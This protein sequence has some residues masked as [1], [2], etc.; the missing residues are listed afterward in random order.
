[1]F[2]SPP[3]PPPPPTTPEEGV[4]A[5]AVLIIL[6][7]ILSQY[8][9]TEDF[10]EKMSQ[11][12]GTL[13][14]VFAPSTSDADVQ[15]PNSLVHD[16][17]SSGILSPPS[18]VPDSSCQKGLLPSFSLKVPDDVN[19]VLHRSNEPYR[20]P[21]RYKV[22][23]KQSVS[24]I[25]NCEDISVSMKRNPSR[26]ELE[27][28][29]DSGSSDGESNSCFEILWPDEDSLIMFDEL[30][31]TSDLENL[32][33]VDSPMANSH[34]TDLDSAEVSSPSSPGEMIEKLVEFILSDESSLIPNT[35]DP[36]VHHEDG[37]GGF[38][39]SFHAQQTHTPFCS[40]Q[41]KPGRV[42]QDPNSFQGNS[43][44]FF[45]HSFPSNTF[46]HPIPLYGDEPGTFGHELKQSTFQQWLN[47]GKPH[48]CSLCVSQSG[49]P[50]HLPAP[51]M[52]S[53]TQ[54]LNSIKSST[55]G[56]QEP[57]FEDFVRP[58]PDFP[59]DSII[60]QAGVDS[61]VDMKLPASLWHPHVGVSNSE[62]PHSSDIRRL[63]KSRAQISGTVHTCPK[64]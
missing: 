20:P 22:L 47:P 53:C 55:F 42:Q 25:D 43:Y 17:S 62:L 7:N 52:A 44:S 5:I 19:P 4:P 56:Y 36:I 54:M 8:S 61:F 2:R 31:S 16:A 39:C 34:E 10:P 33:V 28:K 30:F 59:G 3:P 24:A 12:N 57:N 50:P 23:E 58:N 32:D 27:L 9:F 6:T 49:L 46:S 13:T 15:D 41:W 18:S 1:M 64:L 37:M 14:L 63:A 45:S 26:C 35:D 48:L 60:N 38:F 51:Q 11:E 40:D 29:F 21:C